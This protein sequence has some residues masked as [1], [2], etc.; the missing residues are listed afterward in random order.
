MSEKP[1]SDD[2]SD[3]GC[4]LIIGAIIVGIALG[5][6]FSSAIGWLAIGLSFIAIALAD[7]SA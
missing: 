4:F 7:I 2:A 3:A 6:I 1:K 5:N